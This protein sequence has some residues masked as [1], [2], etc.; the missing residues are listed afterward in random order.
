MAVDNEINLQSN[1]FN[2][3]IKVWKALSKSTYVAASLTYP[4]LWMHI[5]SLKYT[6]LVFA[7]IKKEQ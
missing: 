7:A 2:L 5:F 1:S 4:V 6:H 3:T